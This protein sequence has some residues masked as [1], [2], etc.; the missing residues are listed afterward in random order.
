MSLNDVWDWAIEN[1]APSHILWSIRLARID[2]C[3]HE[4]VE[5]RSGA[6]CGPKGKQCVGC[7]LVELYHRDW[8]R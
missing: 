5:M 1:H 2:L 7:D 4:W 3:E 6:E 8:Q